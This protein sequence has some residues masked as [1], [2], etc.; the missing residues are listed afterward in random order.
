MTASGLAWIGLDFGGPAQTHRFEIPTLRTGSDGGERAA[1]GLRQGA[2]TA[3]C[4]LTSAAYVCL[5]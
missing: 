5:S 1:H 2:R 4:L 3:M